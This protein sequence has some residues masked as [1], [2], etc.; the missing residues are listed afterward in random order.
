[1]K[2]QSHQPLSIVLATLSLCT[3]AIAPFSLI[4]PAIASTQVAQLFP[5][6]P[7]YTNPT[8]PA[9]ARIPARYEAAAKIVVAPN[10]TVPLTLTIPR[11]VRLSNGT[12][13]IPAGSRV[14]GQI[15]PVGEGSQ[16]VAETLI[17]PNGSRQ[18]ISARSEVITTRQEVQPGVN[19]DALIKGSAIGAG[20]AT[21]LSG[22]LGN[23]RITLG[24]ILLGAGA[25]A[26]GGLVFGKKK[27]EV[28]VI[29]S[30]ADL[31]LT[32]DAPLTVGRGF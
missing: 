3:T 23:R 20:A 21:I 1:M 11:T 25:G 27:T 24:R 13:L 2:P 18:P 28:I 8:I 14:S 10:E 5:G 6:A 15:K 31:I 32:L 9:G 29:D 22:I 12:V 4:P 30:N 17:L 19:G 26:A 7:S 16:F